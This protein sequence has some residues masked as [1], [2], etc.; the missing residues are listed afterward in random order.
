MSNELVEVIVAISRELGLRSK[1]PP[2]AELGPET[3]KTSSIS[4]DQQDQGHPCANA[5]NY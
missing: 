1:S 4:L 3:S 5:M 2:S